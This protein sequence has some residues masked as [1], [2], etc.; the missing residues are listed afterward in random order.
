MGLERNRH[1]VSL[2]LRIVANNSSIVSPV[3]EK[4]ILRISLSLTDVD[5]SG[6]V[7]VTEYS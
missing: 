7:G 6:L 1:D 2:A 5:G 3:L 4:S